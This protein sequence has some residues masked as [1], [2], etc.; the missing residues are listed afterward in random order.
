MDGWMD[1]WMDRWM[2][3][4]M[5]FIKYASILTQLTLCNMAA[6]RTP[7]SHARA[8]YCSLS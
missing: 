4:W 2:D 5:L 7:S 6:A 3:R 8:N 1:G